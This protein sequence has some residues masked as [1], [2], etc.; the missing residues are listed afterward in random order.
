[1]KDSELRVNGKIDT[2]FSMYKSDG[3]RWA[4]VW[5]C[6]AIRTWFAARCVRAMVVVQPAVRQQHTAYR[7]GVLRH[8]GGCCLA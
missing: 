2:G 5:C 4:S 3:L 7:H 6:S 8:F 1:M